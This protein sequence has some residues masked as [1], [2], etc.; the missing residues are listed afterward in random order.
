MAILGCLLILRDRATSSDL[1]LD[2]DT[3][4]LLRTIRA[5]HSPFSWFT[6]DWPLYN[7]FY[8]PVS[9][10]AF[11]LDNRLY[12]NAAWGYGLTNALLCV[13]CTLLLF[14]FLRELTDRPW[15]TGVATFIFALWQV[16]L[17]YRLS[18]PFLLLGAVAF[19]GGLMR[20][21]KNW[22]LWLPATLVCYEVSTQ[23]SNVAEIGVHTLHWLPGRTALVMTV[24]ALAAS[25]LYC[26]YERL[27][28]ERVVAKPTP[29]DPPA[30]RNTV[31]FE[32]KS[33]SGFIYPILAI[34]AT[35]LALASYEQAVMVP[36][37]LLACAC[38]FR[39][40]GYRVRWGWQVP[41][42][43]TIAVY[44]VVR[45][46]YIPPSPSHYQLQQFRTGPGVYISL[47]NYLI[48]SL[49]GL[50]SAFQSWVPL[51]PISLISSLEPLGTVMSVASDIATVIQARRRWVLTFAGFGMAFL[52]FLPMAWVKQFNHY[53]YWPLAFKSL[54]VAMLGWLAFDLTLSA[55]SPQTQ[56]AP[57][58]RDPAPGSLPHR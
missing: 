26:R 45:H 25:A 18:D 15:L 13:A 48:P 5:K 23:V 14:W 19:I 30:T 21:P 28:A 47:S 2:S 46:A 54:F 40:Q 6:S 10:L 9:T 20:H 7:H 56:Q 57:P 37:I 16:G 17:G 36:A 27:Y 3:S 33:G 49:F 58:R 34:V 1:L 12:G 39:W 50:E 8:R 31:R 29:L 11:E 44:W 32:P 53:H 42:W 55:V 41:F 43:G 22:R 24:F 51:L 52:A 38:T 4:V 35:L